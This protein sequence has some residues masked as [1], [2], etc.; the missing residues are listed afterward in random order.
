[1][2]VELAVTSKK[3]SESKRKNSRRPPRKWTEEEKMFLK[4]TVPGRHRSEVIA[5]FREKFGVT[6]ETVSD[7]MIIG[8]M[9][10]YGFKTGFTGRY[11]KGHPSPT[12]GRKREEWCPPEAIER[13]KQ[14]QF[15]K[16]AKPHNSVP[17]GSLRF[18]DGFLQVKTSEGFGMAN[19]E[20]LQR[21]VYELFYGE[22]PEE[23]I[24]DFAD[25]NR[26]NMNPS[27]LVLVTRGEHLKANEKIS[28]RETE[29]DA[30]IFLGHVALLR[31]NKILMKGEK[32]GD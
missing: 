14:T 23:M 30:D 32:N 3:S 10:R 21:M 13:I 25:G 28:N 9:K 4:E 29:E 24:V 31:L 12:K 8:A 26:L 22:I 16:G 5:L 6:E 20:L 19:W 7:S 1:M 2:E 15:K 11:E 27:N 17:L 18:S